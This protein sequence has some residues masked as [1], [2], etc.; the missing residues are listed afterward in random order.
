MSTSPCCHTLSLHPSPPPLNCRV[1]GRVLKPPIP[2]KFSLHRSLL[3]IRPLSSSPTT[4]WRFSCLWHEESSSGI[5]ESEL[6]EEKFSEELV[7]P[8]LNRIDAQ[9]DWLCRLR[10]FGR[11]GCITLL[12]TEKDF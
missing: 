8:E 6:L 1:R 12:Q 4:K 7:K 11:C 3:V 5:P 2:A 10:K 9:K